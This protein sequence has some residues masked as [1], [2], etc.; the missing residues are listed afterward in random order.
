M[1]RKSFSLVIFFS[2]ET[3]SHVHPDSVYTVG[4]TNHGAGLV[5][6]WEYDVQAERQQQY[7]ACYLEAAAVVSF[8]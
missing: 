6:S 3:N 8:T 2:P 5:L 7:A 4:L 1:K